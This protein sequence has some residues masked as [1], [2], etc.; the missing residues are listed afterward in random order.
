MQA[1]AYAIL[2][3]QSRENS[4]MSESG[5]DQSFYTANTHRSE[6]SVTLQSPTID[7]QL[8]SEK[9]K[10]LIELNKLASATEKLRQDLL[11]C[12]DNNALI[13]QNEIQPSVEIG[14]T[15]DDRLNHMAIFELTQFIVSRKNIDDLS[16]QQ[17]KFLHDSIRTAGLKKM[18]DQPANRAE[19]T[20]QLAEKRLRKLEEKFKYLR[21]Q[22]KELTTQ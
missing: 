1:V 12:S 7:N 11:N 10:L 3:N 17:L 18:F 21:Q 2:K 16:W 6:L 15:I 22:L 19:F 20:L 9:N 5:D 8:Q 13:G 4:Q 14:A